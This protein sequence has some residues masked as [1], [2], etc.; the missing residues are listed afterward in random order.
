MRPATAPARSTG[1]SAVNNAALQYPGRQARHADPDLHG[2]RRRRPRRHSPPRTSPSPSTAARTRRPSPRRPRP[3]RSP[4]TSLPTSA[5]RQPSTFADVDLSDVHTVSAAAGRAAATSARSRRA[6]ATMR[7]ATAPARSTGASAVNNA[8]LQYPRRRPDT[9]TQTYTVTVDDGTRRHSPPRTSPSP[10]TAPRTRRP[11]PRRSRPARSPKTR[12]R[13]ARPAPSTSPT[14]ISPTP[15]P[16]RRPPAAG[17]YL[18]TFTPSIAN[19]ATGDGTGQVSTGASA[20]NNAALQFLAEGQTADP[21]LYGHRRRRHIGGIATQDVTITITG[22]E[23]APTI[24]AASH[25]GSVTEDTLPTSA[26]H[27]RLRRRRSHRHPHR[28]GDRR[29]PAAISAPSRRASPTIRTGDGTGQV[30]LELRGRQCRA[31]VPGRRPDPDPD[32]HGHR[33]RRHI[34]GTRH[35]RRHHHHHRHRGRADHHRGGRH[36]LGHRRHAADQRGRHHR[37]RRRRSHRHPHRVG[38]P[39]SAAAISAPSRRASPT[40]RPATA[41]ARLP[42]ASR[43]PTP[44]SSIWPAGQTADPDLHGHR[45][46]R[47]RRHVTQDV[48]I[49]ITGTEDAPTITAAAP[50]ARSPKTRCR[51]ARPAPSTSP[52]SI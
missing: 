24:T 22:T 12:C 34:G 39:G 11:S 45:R 25:A 10:S 17:G 29:R 13:P 41:P 23:D 1:A 3:A 21:D 43:S 33:R 27:H 35:P 19:D 14:S 32:L 7:P 16:C 31:P 50:P 28:V 8:A 44:R 18:G 2:H 48:T 5:S 36:R 26:R 42:G 9:L 38:G 37:L 52:T 49:T 15:T 46:R 6:S 51:P 4:K 30:V 20:V 40:M 47:P